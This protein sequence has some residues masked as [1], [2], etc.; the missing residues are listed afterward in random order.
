[1]KHELRPDKELT[2]GTARTSAIPAKVIGRWLLCW[3]C[4]RPLCRRGPGRHVPVAGTVRTVT[5]RAKIRSDDTGAGFHSGA[6]APIWLAVRIALGHPDQG[7]AE[8]QLNGVY[9]SHSVVRRAPLNSTLCSRECRCWFA[10]PTPLA[11]SAPPHA[12]RGVPKEIRRLCGRIG[13][14]GQ[15]PSPSGRAGWGR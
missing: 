10:A 2:A 5:F 13:V 8:Q 11:Q 9:H 1:M 14:A 7:V 4:R 12:L 15:S 6:V 3:R